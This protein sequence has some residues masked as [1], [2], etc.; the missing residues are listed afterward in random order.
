VAESVPE[1]GSLYPRSN[2][3][4]SELVFASGLRLTG[5]VR[6]PDLCI[7]VVHTPKLPTQRWKPIGSETSKST[8]TARAL[9][10]KMA[11]RI[12]VRIGTGCDRGTRPSRNDP[13]LKISRRANKATQWITV[14]TNLYRLRPEEGMCRQLRPST[15]I[16]P[17]IRLSVS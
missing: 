14:S 13:I 6:V 11:V 7:L 15:G 1:D 2:D 12:G 17:S 16:D 5:P 10:M 9:S 4:E 8:R 3:N